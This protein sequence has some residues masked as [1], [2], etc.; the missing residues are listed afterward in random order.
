MAVRVTI[1]AIQAARVGRCIVSSG[2]AAD[3][4]LLVVV[5]DGRTVYLS[6]GTHGRR[7]KVCQVCQVCQA[8]QACPD[9]FYGKGWSE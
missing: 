7:W 2:P 4:W 9:M 6:R 3:W 5:R 1:G 8:C